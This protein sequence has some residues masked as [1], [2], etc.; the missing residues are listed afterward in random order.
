MEEKL[1][2]LCKIVEDV[3][4]D[5]NKIKKIY[6]EFLDCVELDDDYLLDEFLNESELFFEVYEE[7]IS[8]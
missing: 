4:A 7:Y 2:T 1:I 6:R 3:V 5:E 8:L